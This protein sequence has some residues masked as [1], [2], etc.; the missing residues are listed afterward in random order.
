MKNGYT[1]ALAS[2]KMHAIAFLRSPEEYNLDISRLRNEFVSLV[3][4]MSGF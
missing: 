3:I 4:I 1:L 2:L